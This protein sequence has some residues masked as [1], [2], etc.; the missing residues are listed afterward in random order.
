MLL[1][2]PEIHPPSTMDADIKLSVVHRVKKNP[3]IR[4]LQIYFLFKK[5]GGKGIIKMY[6][7][8]IFFKKKCALRDLKHRF[9]VLIRGCY[10]S[11]KH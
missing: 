6:T 1:V 8:K 3:F 7:N 10:M 4:H 11:P 5:H 2:S 9:P